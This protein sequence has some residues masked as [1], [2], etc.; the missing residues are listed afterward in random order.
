M[1]EFS[2]ALAAQGH[3]VH[4][5]AG[6][7]SDSVPGGRRGQVAVHPV[8]D[9]MDVRHFDWVGN[10]VLDGVRLVEAGLEAADEHGPFDLIMSEGWTCAHSARSLR[11]ILGL[12]WALVMQETEVGKRGKRVTRQQLYAAEME[13]WACEQADHVLTPGEPARREL[14]EICKVQREKVTVA[15]WGVEP[16]RFESDTDIDDFR[17]LFAAPNHKLV[18]FVGELAPHTGVEDL[19]EAVLGL[20]ARGRPVQLVLGGEGFL[21]E[22]LEKRFEEAGLPGRM[23]LAGWLSPKV[24][25]A[26]YRAADLVVVP[27]RYGPSGLPAIEAAA[28]GACV[29]ACEAGALADLVEGS[30]GAIIGVPPQDPEQLR[31]AM[32]E[33]LSNQGKARG[34]GERARAHVRETYA[35]KSAAQAASALLS[36]LASSRVRTAGRRRRR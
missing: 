8:S 25:G 17:G 1:E 13:T 23:C 33:L 21:G 3:E 2:R 28:C 15:P 6:G 16:S 31:G 5:V 11:A 29:V 32:E 10:A 27:S 14:E 22:S 26:L 4:V 30:S 9:H 19:A 18:A 34:L 24:R 35:W 36:K 20:A 12:T 7:P